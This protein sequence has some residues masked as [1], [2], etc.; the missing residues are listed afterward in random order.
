MSMTPPV[1]SIG[2]AELLADTVRCTRRALL[3]S[4][5]LLSG[6]V[7]LA[8]WCVYRVMLSSEVDWATLG[9]V[10]IPALTLGMVAYGA[11]FRLLLDGLDGTPNLADAIGVGFRRYLPILATQ[12]LYGLAV[13]LGTLL[14]IVPGIFLSVA[15]AISLP[16]ALE[17]EVGPI[18][19]LLRAWD[20]TKGHRWVAI[21]ALLV[22]S[23]VGTVVAMVG[24]LLIGVVAVGVAAVLH[25]G[26]G[27]DQVG[28]TFD[29]AFTVFVFLSSLMNTLSNL[30]WMAPIA[31]LHRRLSGP[32]HE[33]PPALGAP[34]PGA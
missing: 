1:R 3:P 6:L 26:A 22:V 14:C 18:E 32:R 17:E 20:R 2:L 9:I 15:L 28:A 16:I 4:L 27:S 21:A 34:L 10:M 33:P 7:A 19:A 11:L 23:A 8:C 31:A 25:A 12:L 5:P 24:S 29:V 30:L 13:G